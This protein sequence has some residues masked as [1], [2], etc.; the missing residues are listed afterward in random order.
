M[1]AVVTLGLLHTTNAVKA[2]ATCGWL[3][4]DLVIRFELMR[5]ILWQWC[6]GRKDSLITDYSPRVNRVVSTI[7][8]A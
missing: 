2:L 1:A 4:V 8:V 3:L 6:Y 7:D 5:F